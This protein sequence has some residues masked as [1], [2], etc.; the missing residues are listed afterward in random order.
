MMPPAVVNGYGPKLADR[1]R[2]NSGWWAK[3]AWAI[4]PGCGRSSGVPMVQVFSF[5]ALPAGAPAAVQPFYSSCSNDV[6][7]SPVGTTSSPMKTPTLSMKTPVPCTNS[8]E[9]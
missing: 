6:V 7:P 2:R 8:S 3:V 9:A 1:N 5:A 4:V